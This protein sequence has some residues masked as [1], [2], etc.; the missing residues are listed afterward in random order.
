LITSV[1]SFESLSQIINDFDLYGVRWSAPSAEVMEQMKRAIVIEPSPG[2]DPTFT[3]RFEY[4]NRYIAQRVT[5][6]LV[7]RMIEA[8]L[9][10]AIVEVDSGSSNQ[11]QILDPPT[12]AE[13]PSGPSRLKITGEGLLAGLCGGILLGWVVRMHGKSP[14]GEPVS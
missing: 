3:M 2:H 6:E 10:L 14:A 9:R 12:L 13:V 4:P 5:Q 11:M 7:S 1:E 8:N